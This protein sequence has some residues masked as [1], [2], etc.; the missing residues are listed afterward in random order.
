MT[1][2]ETQDFV[3]LLR[4]QNDAMQAMI[5]EKK[6]MIKDMP[7]L[8][9]EN[10]HAGCINHLIKAIEYNVALIDKVQHS[11]TNFTM[12]LVPQDNL[13]RGYDMRDPWFKHLAKYNLLPLHDVAQEVGYRVRTA[14][15]VL[16]TLEYEGGFQKY[17]TKEFALKLF[18]D[19]PAGREVALKFLRSVAIDIGQM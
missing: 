18:D 3:N 14:D 13:L 11:D 5:D 1:E 19:T 6:I 10:F 15:G 17:R 9:V 16:F 8:A 12:Q 2:A 4:K 7:G